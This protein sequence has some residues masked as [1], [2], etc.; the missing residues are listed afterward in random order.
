M[1]KLIIITSPLYVRNYVDTSAFK[2]II[3]ENTFIAC[4]SDISNKKSI[5][6]DAN[7]VGEFES[8]NLNKSLYTFFTLLIMYSKRKVGKGFYF[9]FKI[10]HTTIYY[11]SLRL[12]NKVDQWFPNKLINYIIILILEF[13]RP[14][15]HP[16]SL[17]K[18]L[19]IVLIDFLGLTKK[20]VKVYNLLLNNNKEL[21]SIIEKVNP[22]LV[23]VPNGG[24][25]PN[26][27]EVLALSAQ[28]N[29]KTMLLID[30]WDNLCSKASFP[31]EPDYLCVWGDQAKL[32]A[33]E[34]HQI[35]SSR[36]F[37]AGTPRFDG[38]QVYNQNEAS[39]KEKYQ[40]ILSF[41]YI[42]FAGCWPAF[43]E[44]GVLEALN[45]LVEKYKNLLPKNCKILY[46]PHP[47]G[48]SYDKLD[49]LTAKNLKNIAIDPQMAKKSRPL[50]WTKRTDFQPDLDYY[51]I[52]LD[53]SEFVICPLATIIIEASLMGKKV[54]ALAHDDGKNFLNPSFLYKNSDYFDHLSDIGSVKLLDNIMNLDESF[55]Q[56]ITSDAIVNRKALSYYIVDEGQLY[57]DRIANICDKLLLN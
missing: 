11:P 40:E 8:S 34:F 54:L 31:I 1:K 48:E 3:D 17:F 29:F 28:N 55:N 36:V 5:V 51:P 19:L 10:R 37:L 21:Q 41:P 23:L 33:K 39:L 45:K 57:H 47:W 50:D 20:L 46:R 13:S 32:H 38:Y 49:E 44:I 42:L 18:F 43:D 7:F 26:A 4:T 30:N 24:L 22:D 16:L 25:D 2:K 9:Y 56:M 15:F 27:H 53:N 52:L 6:N 12:K 35:D 14:F